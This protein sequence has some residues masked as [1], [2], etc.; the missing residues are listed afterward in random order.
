MGKLSIMA[1][2]LCGMCSTIGA[3][4]QKITVKGDREL[5]T[6]FGKYKTFYWASQVDQK[7]DPGAYFLNDLILKADV[8]DAV[9]HEMEGLGYRSE[10]MAPDLIINFRVFDKPVRIKGYESYGESYWGDQEVR[11]PSDTTSYA[12]KA[13]TLLISLVDRKKGNIVWQGFAS[14]LINNNEFIKDEGKIKEAVNLIFKEYGMR[15]TDYDRSAR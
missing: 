6:D 8:R 7:L 13:G 3:Q 2:L 5:N 9:K 15:A 14:G 1:L 10:P 4:A 11:V 12:V